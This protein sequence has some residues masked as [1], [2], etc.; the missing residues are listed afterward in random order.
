MSAE[1]DSLV[2]AIVNDGL[3][4]EAK[5]RANV[6]D[7]GA[8]IEDKKPYQ[9]LLLAWANASVRVIEK[10]RP[11]NFGE[12]SLWQRLWWNIE[13]DYELLSLQTGI[14]RD[15]IEGF[16]QV[17]QSMYWIFPDG[18]VAADALNYIKAR[19]SIRLRLRLRQP[20]EEPPPKDL[21]KKTGTKRRQRRK[22][23]AQTD[24]SLEGSN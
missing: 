23:E 22:K 2:P 5:L 4:V 24:A 9:N 11:E 13:I 20:A 6:L 7:N 16:V 12:L 18:T 15:L 14:D 21:K 3:L 17:A 19:I 1:D 8:L 10:V